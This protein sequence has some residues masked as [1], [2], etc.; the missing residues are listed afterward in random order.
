MP[1][2]T[3]EDIFKQVMEQRNYYRERF[4]TGVHHVVLGH[5]EFTRLNAANS[6]WFE[7]ELG[8]KVV[9][10][11]LGIPVEVDKKFSGVMVVPKRTY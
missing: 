2:G 4:N 6:T 9:G 3:A 7:R 5:K 1:E 10:R 8:E 11:I